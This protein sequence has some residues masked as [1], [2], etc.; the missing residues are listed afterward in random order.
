MDLFSRHEKTV[1]QVLK[2]NPAA[3][4]NM[5]DFYEAGGVPLVL[6]ELAPILHTGGMTV[7]GVTMGEVIG[8]VPPRRDPDNDL[9]R[10][11]DDPYSVGHGIA[12]VKGNLAPLGGVTKPAAI[13][14]EQ[15]VFS[16]KAKVYDS[17]DD[18]IKDILGGKISEGDLLV[19]RY[20]GPKGGPGMREMCNAMKYLHGLGLGTSTA[21]ITDGRFSGTNNG[22]FVGH[23]SPEA[24][25]G[26]PIAAVMNGDEIML[27]IPE[28]S[29]T[30]NVDEEEI[31]RR[32]S[33]VKM[34]EERFKSGY[35]AEYSRNA[36]SASEGAVMK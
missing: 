20:E 17:E 7:D 21:I 33:N 35:L 29:I 11:M 9:I 13:A 6:K 28:N 16:G 26:G 19:I 18:A 10:T 8:Q 5:D 36:S 25:E 1:P 24:A 34:P 4:A 2:I 14:E 22:C 31:K 32:L 15:L 27:N 23:I 30:L 3:V 12:I